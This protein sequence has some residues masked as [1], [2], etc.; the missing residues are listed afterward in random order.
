MIFVLSRIEWRI[1]SP[2]DVTGRVQYVGER[3]KW[4]FQIQK[5]LPSK[6]SC[7]HPGQVLNLWLSIVIFEA[8][9]QR[10]EAVVDFMSSLE[11]NPSSTMY[12]SLLWKNVRPGIV[13]TVLGRL[14][15]AGKQ[16]EPVA[17]KPFCGKVK[18]IKQNEMI[19]HLVFSTYDQAR[20]MVSAVR[21][22]QP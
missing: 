17:P 6:A 3:I 16:M 10:Q 20:V 13:S 15:V 4:F 18:L 5:E 19:K 9:A 11:G 2:C 12:S 22:R 14:A 1:S 8:P 21:R 7:K